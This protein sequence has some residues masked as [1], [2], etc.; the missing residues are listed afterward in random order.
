MDTKLCCC[1]TVWLYSTYLFSIIYACV[2]KI[3]YFVL[4]LNSKSRHA[5]SA[6]YD[7]EQKVD[8][9]DNM[10]LQRYAKA[11]SFKPVGVLASKTL[12]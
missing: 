11:D 4:Q 12:C 6:G 7:M 1:Y 3:N 2:V 5:H 9:M 8:N 10:L